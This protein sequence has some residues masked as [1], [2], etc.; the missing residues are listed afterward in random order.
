MEFEV[1]KIAKGLKNEKRILTLKL[2]NLTLTQ[3]RLTEKDPH[4]K[5][6]HFSTVQKVLRSR[7]NPLIV[8][9][10]SLYDWVPLKTISDERTVVFCQCHLN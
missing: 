8:K 10:I 6:K 4:I 2:Q 3:K 7:T 1:E 5:I 9:I